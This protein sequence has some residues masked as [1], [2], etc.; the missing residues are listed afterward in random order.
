MKKS[1]AFVGKNRKNNIIFVQPVT[2]NI[3]QWDKAN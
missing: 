3:R 2:L 1:V